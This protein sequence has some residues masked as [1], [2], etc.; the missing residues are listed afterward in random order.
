MGVIFMMIWAI[1][2]NWLLPNAPKW[3]D[4]EKV[5]VRIIAMHAFKNDTQVC[6]CDRV[7]DTQGYSVYGRVIFFCA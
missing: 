7:T 5:L 4:S 3:A 1:C 6:Y 2:K